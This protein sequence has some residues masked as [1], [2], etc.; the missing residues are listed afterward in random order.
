M[1][2]PAVIFEMEAYRQKISEL[3]NNESTKTIDSLLTN[4]TLSNSK[5]I[6]K[7]TEEIFVWVNKEL[8]YTEFRNMAIRLK[9]I[10]ALSKDDYSTVKGLLAELFFVITIKEFIKLNKLDDWKLYHSLIIP[11]K[12]KLGSTE[13]DIVIVNKYI[14]V[15]C[16]VKSYNGNKKLTKECTISTSSI[17]KDLRQQNGMH[18]KALWEHIS[19]ASLTEIGALKSVF[20]SFSDGTLKDN[21]SID[22]KQLMPCV[23]ENNIIHFLNALKN[24]NHISWKSNIYSIFEE[25]SGCGISAEEHLKYVQNLHG[26]R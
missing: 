10:E 22:N 21:R 6:R 3:G 17:S 20:L 5:D 13:I 24:V 23:D 12:S 16:E 4:I 19:S 15:V 11:F 7:R 8:G 1:N 25:L 14:V 18:C 9:R 2:I 26:D